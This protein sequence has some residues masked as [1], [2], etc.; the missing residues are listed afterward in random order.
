MIRPKSAT[1]FSLIELLLVLAILGIIS[2]IAVPSFLMQRRRAR[3]IGDAQAN[4]AG[5]RMQFETYKADNGVYAS[6]A[7][8]YKWL[9]GAFTGSVNP[10]PNFSAGNS[11]MN[12]TLATSASGLTYV[13]SVTDPT[14]GSTLVYKTNQNG[15]NLYTLH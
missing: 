13:L 6:A 14:M 4:S 7:K 8:T 10:V 15:S 1:G 12:F 5:L 3:V 9:Q 11:K 2:G